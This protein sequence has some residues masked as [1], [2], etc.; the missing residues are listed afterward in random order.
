M[1]RSTHS[2]EDAPCHD[3]AVQV[4]SDRRYRFPVGPEDLW[5]VLTRVEDY[6][7]WWPWLRRFDAVAFE[8]GA[9]W[10]C[11][12]QPPLPYS[13]RFRIVLH[14]VDPCRLATATIDGDI[15]GEARLELAATEA[16]SE[17]RL[18]SSLAPENAVLRA[19]AGV[20]RPVAQFGHDWVLDSG[21]RQFRSRALP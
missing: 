6:R 5:P 7:S 11:V 3:G 16:G 4:R 18:V 19:I 12:V 2:R 13:L 9:A 8:P 21:L 20:A 15:V 17:A 14:E 10:T 1:S